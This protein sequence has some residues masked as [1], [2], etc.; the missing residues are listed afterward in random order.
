MRWVAPA[1]RSGGDWASTSGASTP[2]ARSVA[3]WL[4]K[5]V[6][7]RTLELATAAQRG[8][9]AQ[10]VRAAL[11]GRNARVVMSVTKPDPGAWRPRCLPQGGTCGEDDSSRWGQVHEQRLNQTEVFNHSALEAR[12]E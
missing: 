1:R 5:T 10:A 8:R 4:T 11:V 12:R 2:G 9:K 7:R 3:K 6:T